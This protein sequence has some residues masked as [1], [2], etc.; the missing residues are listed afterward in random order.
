MGINCP[1]MLIFR[2]KKTAMTDI[3]TVFPVPVAGLFI[4]LP[5]LHLSIFLHFDYPDQ[6]QVLFQVHQLLP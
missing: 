1:F 5:Y 3:M 2:H 4:K 6:A